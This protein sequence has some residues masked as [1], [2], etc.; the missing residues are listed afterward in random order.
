MRQF[1]SAAGVAVISTV[2]AS[3]ISTHVDA[4]DQ[5]ATPY[6]QVLATFSGYEDTF[7][8]SAALALVGIAVVFV[9]RK[10]TGTPQMV[11]EI[12]GETPAATRELAGAMH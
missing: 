7:L 3:R 4:L 12:G 1:A 5:T 6:D 2:L 11:A 9:Y 8:V 10:D